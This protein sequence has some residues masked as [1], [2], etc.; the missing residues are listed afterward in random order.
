MKEK[1]IGMELVGTANALRRI[2][3]QDGYDTKSEPDSPTSMQQWFLSY[4]WE[5]YKSDTVVQKDLETAFKIRR[6]TATEILKAMER[7]ELIIRIPSSEDKRS[8]KI[9]LTDKAISICEKN[10]QKISQTEKKLVAGLSPKEIQQF[11]AILKK[12]QINI[13]NMDTF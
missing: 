12:I 2:T 1:M 5:H 6:S 7:K 3:F 10:Q 8:K 9:V 11:L 4:I 13:K